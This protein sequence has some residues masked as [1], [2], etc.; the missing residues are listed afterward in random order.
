MNLFGENIPKIFI[1]S[2]IGVM[3]GA[4]VITGITK[5]KTKAKAENNLKDE[6][7]KKS[8]SPKTRQTTR[9]K[10]RM[11]ESLL[12]SKIRTFLSD[13]DKNSSSEDD[14]FDSRHKFAKLQNIHANRPK[15]PSPIFAIQSDNEHTS[16]F[17]F[18]PR[19]RDESESQKMDSLYFA[20]VRKL[21]SWTAAL[22]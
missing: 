6:S 8:Q 22:N 21:D 4:F 9:E 13:M 2:S 1:V 17:N 14:Q 15:K 11:A 16:A 18:R 12:K 20:L 5:S 3:L 7:A 19:A 10:G